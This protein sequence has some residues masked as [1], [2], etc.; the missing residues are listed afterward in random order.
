M[1]SG[2]RRGAGRALVGALVAGLVGGCA[3]ILGIGDLDAGALAVEAG[4]DATVPEAGPVDAGTGEGACMPIAVPDAGTGVCQGPDGGVCTPS[5]TDTCGA[6]AGGTCGPSPIDAAALAWLP[7]RPR[8]AACTDAQITTYVTA[9]IDGT[10]Q[11]CSAFLGGAGNAGCGA[12]ITDQTTTAAPAS[13]SFPLQ[14]PSLISGPNFGGCIA[15]L[16]P[17]NLACAESVFLWTQCE[18]LSCTPTCSGAGTSSGEITGCITAAG[19]CPC[20]QYV[21]AG[22]ACFAEILA[23]RSA[24]VSCIPSAASTIEDYA[25]RV[26]HAFCT[27]E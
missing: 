17:C 15:L 20:Y 1:R 2:A 22:Q 6:D 12:C 14:P 21:V 18:A 7:P 4:P 9:C 13:V 19:A 23:R 3:D 8:Q 11:A 24:A 16:E 25:S 27:L 26:A 5:I 10:P